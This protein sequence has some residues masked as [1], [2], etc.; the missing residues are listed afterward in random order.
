MSKKYITRQ[1][2]WLS[3][4]LCLGRAYEQWTGRHCPS[5]PEVH[6]PPKCGL[7]H[8]PHLGPGIGDCRMPII[9]LAESLTYL[10]ESQ[11]RCGNSQPLR[12]WPGLHDVIMQISPLHLSCQPVNSCYDSPRCKR[13]ATESFPGIEKIVGLVFCRAFLPP[14]PL[15]VSKNSTSEQ[16]VAKYPI[17]SMYGIFTYIWLMVN[18]SKYTSPMDP[19]GMEV[20][21]FFVGGMSPFLI[22][23]VSHKTTFFNGWK[24]WNIIFYI[25]IWFAI[26]LKQPSQ[27]CMF[28]V[29]SLGKRFL[30]FLFWLP[31]SSWIPRTKKTRKNNWI[32]L[33][34]MLETSDPKIVPS[35]WRALMVISSHGIESVKK[36][37]KTRQKTVLLSSILVV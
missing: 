11:R 10:S 30:R 37:K 9:R 20:D 34:T 26:H 2:W 16:E 14:T 27:K 12:N 3:G 24:W 31:G 32:C 13:I 19:M 8:L 6:L 5:A 18:V 25:R 29:L 17:A 23:A 28:R 35:K 7:E 21:N 4:W 1:K 15:F 36:H 33:A 22:L